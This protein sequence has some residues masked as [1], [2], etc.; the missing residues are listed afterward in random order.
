MYIQIQPE[1]EQFIQTQ[2]G[3]GKFATADDVINEAL[4]L[5]QEK[6]KRIAELQQKIAMGEEL[7]QKIAVEIEQ[8]TKGQ[9]TDTDFQPPLNEFNGLRVKIPGRAEVYLVDQG[10]RRWIPNPET[11][12]NLFRDWNNIIEEI[13][14]ANIPLGANI[15]NGAILAK[16]YDHPAVFLIDQGQKRHI[17]SPEIMNKYHFSWEHIYQIPIILLESIATGTSIIN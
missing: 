10:Y 15:S 13:T 6:E 11:Y 9:V 8:M 4:K 12:N 5:L 17:T 2:I 7:R 14:V 3:N 1:L 16:A